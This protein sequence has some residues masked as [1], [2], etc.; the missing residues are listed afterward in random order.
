MRWKLGHINL[1]V[2]VCLGG[3]WD[4]IV[5]VVVVVVFS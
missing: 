2:T 1:G 4:L 5:V 3:K